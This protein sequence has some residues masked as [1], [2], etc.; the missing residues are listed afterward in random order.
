MIAGQGRK[1]GRV[2]LQALLEE[3]PV[4]LVVGTSAT[5][6]AAM[7][8]SW[9]GQAPLR[10]P[11]VAPALILLF[12]SSVVVA[13]RYLLPHSAPERAW[14]CFAPFGWVLV[15]GAASLVVARESRVEWFL[16]GDNV[17]HLAYVADIVGNGALDYSENP[18]PRAWHALLAIGWLNFDGDVTADSL[19]GFLAMNAM[20]TWVLF[21]V[22]VLATSSAAAAI[23]RGVGLSGRQVMASAL[24]AGFVVSTPRFMA[25]TMALGFQT[26]VLAAVVLA[27][28]ARECVIERGSSVRRALVLTSSV[29]LMA[30]TW[31]LLLPA[32]VLPALILMWRS[33]EPDPATSVKV[34]L[35][36]AA[37]AVA[38]FPPVVA[39]VT[40][41]GAGHA[42]LHG[43]VGSPP[44]LSLGL[45]L[46]AGMS[47]LPRL[48]RT[49]A[50][51]ACTVL[52]G[53]TLVAI[54][55]AVAFSIPLEAYYP[56]KL[57]WHSAVIGIILIAPCS[58]MMSRAAAVRVLPVRLAGATLT[59]AATAFVL[60][61]L[62]TPLGSQLGWWSTVDSS[63]VIRAAVAPGSVEAHGVW[64]DTPTE[65]AVTRTL[66]SILRGEA[67]IDDRP[68]LADECAAL[69]TAREPVVV[70][71]RST[72]ATVDRYDCVDGLLV[73]TA[74]G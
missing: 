21:A 70:S 65:S 59:L 3:L 17:R 43:V 32:V 9:L 67:V 37:G 46:V 61:G 45:S 28:L 2:T 51:A 23:A 14:L 72:T 36:A 13:M 7:G 50:V 42:S 22:L 64:L 60:W 25:D 18:Y 66:L 71:A 12:L 39:V 53:P 20:A 6:V 4:A 44:W 8:I 10:A 62:V 57:L 73:V 31:Q 69:R 74:S 30:H 63:R 1:G 40:G 58:V 34:L 29:V 54:G 48:T 35:L 5:T 56:T 15:V 55:I 52:A 68:S 24:I 19:P 33:R 16:G 49:S 27:V 47:V 26:S 38:C 41:F 11:A